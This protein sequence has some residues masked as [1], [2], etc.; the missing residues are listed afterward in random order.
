MGNFSKSSLPPASKK[1]ESGSA[2][3]SNPTVQLRDNRAEHAAQL[4]FAQLANSR[5]A[6]EAVQRKELQEEEVQLAGIEE[7]ELQMKSVDEEEEL[8]M[9]SVESPTDQSETPVQR[10]E[11]NTG[12][13]DQLKSGVENLSGYSLDDVKVHYNSDKPSQL[14]AH[15]YAQGTDI[16][17]APGQEKHLPHE[18]WH[19]VQQKQGRVK[20]TRQLKGKVNINDDAGLEN[21]ADVMG[22][23]ALQRREKG[24]VPHQTP[25]TSQVV[26]RNEDTDMTDSRMDVLVKRVLAILGTLAANGNDWEKTYGDK[27]KDLGKQAVK[28]G[29]EKLLG[30]R[31]NQKPSIKEKIVKE[32]LKRWWAALEPEQKAEM[33][34]ESTSI[35]SGWFGGSSGGK[36]EEQSTAPQ[37]EPKKQTSKQERFELDITSQDLETLYDTYKG[38]KEIKDQIEKIEE[39]AR[40]LAGRIGSEVGMKVGEFRDEREFISKFEEQRVPFKVAKLEFAFLKETILTKNVQARYKAELEA[41]EDALDP[42]LQKPSAMINNPGL[43]TANKEQM[44]GAVETCSIAYENLKLANL[45][46]NG[47]TS[48]LSNIGKVIDSVVE[49]GKKILG[50]IFGSSS[51]VEQVSPEIGKKQKELV[52]AIQTVC[53]K[54]WYWHTSGILAFKP[55]GVTEVGEKLKGVK[56]GKELAQIK[57][58]LTKPEEDLIQTES[59]ISSTDEQIET[60]SGSL[61]K[62]VTIDK[63]LSET[64]TKKS[65]EKYGG[66]QVDNSSK[67]AELGI[68]RA[69]LALEKRNLKKKIKGENRKPLTQVFYNAIKDLQPDNVISLNK[70]IAVMNQIAGELD[71]QN[72]TKNL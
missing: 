39:G 30:N 54:S 21:E 8:Q 47:T 25:I 22:A 55:T 33:L 31:D 68:E 42:S 65:T 18:A 11:N 16:H 12:L 1:Q 2:K 43:F 5:R 4:K 71:N 60:L 24:I 13:P 46:R 38:Y 64:R 66:K 48:L 26:Q 9:K 15:A 14:Q 50:G 28:K 61:Q 10:V 40:E 57:A 59:E 49:G 17:V 3:G 7:K 53:G 35:F 6:D 51:E 19:V 29:K 72:H 41:L 63:V 23:K 37:Q 70:T 45:I 58:H 44:A 62:D 32:G 20:A 27:G 52:T 69:R 36:E 56:P 34:K 67:L